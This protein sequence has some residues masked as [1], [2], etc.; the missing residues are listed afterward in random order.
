MN[1]EELIDLCKAGDEHALSLLY[2]NYAPKLKR[3]CLRYVSDEATAEDILHD[4]FIIIMSSIHQLKDASKLE[5]WMAS[6]MRNLAIRHLEHNGKIL[7]APIEEAEENEKL[8]AEPV[9]IAS[10]YKDLLHLVAML[11]DGYKS[12]FNLSVFD[13]MSHKEIS[14]LL[15]INPH[16]SSS[17]LARAK[18][19]LRTMV[20]VY[21][22]VPVLVVALLYS[23]ELKETKDNFLKT[24]TNNTEDRKESATRIVKRANTSIPQPVMIGK[25]APLS[26]AVDVDKPTVEKTDTTKEE[27]KIVLPKIHDGNIAADDYY[28]KTKKQKYATWTASVSYTGAADANNSVFS[29]RPNIGSDIDP[30]ETVETRTHH[31]MPFIVSLSLHKSIGKNWSIGTG[32]RYTR[33]KTDITTIGEYETTKESQTVEYVGIPLSVSYNLWRTGNLSIYSSTGIIADMPVSGS[34]TWQWSLSAGAGLQYNLTPKVSLFAE[35]SLNYHL[36]SNHGTPTIWTD[37]PLDVTVP[38]GLR[39]SW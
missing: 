20:T 24:V 14:K 28:P 30:D 25:A 8:S 12:V 2:T 15:G 36:N 38:L 9:E 23:I 5:S 22:F 26:P 27:R 3:L 4:G 19:M 7:F 17:Q 32:L 34:K 33:H 31:Y 21:G 37:R 16:S 35:P 29:T 11:P 13:G 18:E 39:I 1:K 10:E 6:I